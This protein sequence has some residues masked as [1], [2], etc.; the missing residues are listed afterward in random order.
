MSNQPQEHDIVCAEDDYTNSEEPD[1]DLYIND[2][3]PSYESR[4]YVIK[5][6]KKPRST[7]SEILLQRDEEKTLDLPYGSYFKVKGNSDI[8]RFSPTSIRY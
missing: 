1:C 5:R 4:Y 2:F 7:P 6:A 3:F 8:F